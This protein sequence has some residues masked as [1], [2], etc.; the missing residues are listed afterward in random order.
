MAAVKRHPTNS[1]RPYRSP[2]R[3]AQARA[4]RTAIVEA[5]LRRFVADGYAGTTIEAIAGDADVSAATVYGTFGSKRALLSAAVDASVRGEDEDIPLAEQEWVKGLAALPDT[6]TKLRRVFAGLR[7][8]YEHTAGIERVVEEAASTDAE[9]AELARELWRRQ[10]QDAANFRSF[11]IG[12]GGAVFRGLT[13]DQDRDA[14]W[15][16]TGLTVFRRLVEECGWSPDQW[17]RWVVDLC[18]RLLSTR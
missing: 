17:E 14:L 4:T 5:A 3:Q 9:I 18:E 12:D 7:V 16:L 8:V 13:P 1:P 2:R 11:F 10:R 15:S 6:G